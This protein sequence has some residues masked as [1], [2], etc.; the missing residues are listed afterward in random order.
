MGV[1]FG[2][3]SVKAGK[4]VS[5]AMCSGTSFVSGA[6]VPVKFTIGGKDAG[7]KKTFVLDSKGCASG[8]VKLKSSSRGTLTAQVS[9]KGKKAKAT[10]KVSK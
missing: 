1:A 2:K 8:S 6:K 7:I 3:S 10:T 4:S 9:Y 5:L